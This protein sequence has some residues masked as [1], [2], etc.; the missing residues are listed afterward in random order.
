[1]ERNTSLATLKVLRALLDNISPK[2]Y[3]L[4]LSERSGVTTGALYPILS[5]LEADGWVEG[6]WEDIDESLAGRRRRRYYRLTG[7]GEIRARQATMTL[8]TS[9]TR[10]LNWNG[11]WWRRQ[12]ALATLTMQAEV[13]RLGGVRRSGR[14]R[15]R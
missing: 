8:A 5:R 7:L 13:E 14:V 6:E 15:S 2:H 1:M 9:P 12:A 10:K 3:G 11:Q 4:E